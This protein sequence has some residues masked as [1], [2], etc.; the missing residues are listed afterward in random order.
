MNHQTQEL[1]TALLRI[2]LGIIYLA[3]SVYLKLFVFTLSGTVAYFESIGLPVFVAYG[4]F[5][6]EALGGLALVIGYQSRLV[7]LALIPIAL[8][9]TWAHSVAGWVF[10]A[11]GGGWEYP[12]FLAVTTA[13][14][15]VQG[16]GAWS[17]QERS[18]QK[19]SLQARDNTPQV[20]TV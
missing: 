10:N 11:E 13:V 20:Q 6:V 9:A 2:S 12:L 7:A 1:G 4:T 16:N 5:L 3:H 14:V 8:G 17:I 18:L 15:A 19:R